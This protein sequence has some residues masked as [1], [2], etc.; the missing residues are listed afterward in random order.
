MEHVKL[1][2]EFLA[3]WFLIAVVLAITIG[4]ILKDP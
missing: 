2:I 1:I 3:C 4:K